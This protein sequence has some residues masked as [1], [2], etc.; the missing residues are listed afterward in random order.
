[1]NDRENGNCASD[2][3]QPFVPIGN[4]KQNK[5]NKNK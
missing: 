1:M 5:Y 2:S 3:I 4:L